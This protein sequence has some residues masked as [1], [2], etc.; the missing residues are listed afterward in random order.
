MASLAEKEISVDKV[1]KPEMVEI[2][3]K[4][5]DIFKNEL[6]RLNLDNENPE[7]VKFK[8]TFQALF[9]QPVK[10]SFKKFFPVIREISETLNKKVNFKLR[11]DECSLEKETLAILSDAII[12][13]VRNALDHGI[14]QP[15]KRV[16]LG[17][18]EEGLI[19]IECRDGIDG[20]L[21]IT[22]KDDGKGIDGNYLTN[23]AIK[24]GIIDNKKGNMLNDE[25]KINLIFLPN[26][27]TKKIVSDLSGRG[28]GM[29]VVKN[30][31]EKI[32]A[33]LKI[34]TAINKGTSFIIKIPKKKTAKNF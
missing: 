5:F 9:D 21:E 10:Y 23:S 3:S 4:N 30:N 6:K 11:G 14:E 16:S 22:L 24:K 1:Q 26:F 27:S 15:D 28:V 18:E 17:K 19:E 29:D 25:E 8:S 31:L 7:I 20:F 32:K 13:I 12:H 33:D 2:L 34:E